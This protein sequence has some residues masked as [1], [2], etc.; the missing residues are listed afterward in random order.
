[1]FNIDSFGHSDMLPQILRG[2]GIDSYVFS[3]PESYHVELPDKLFVWRS[4]NGS[5]VTAYRAA[6]LY[7]H[8]PDEVVSTAEKYIKEAADR[9]GQISRIWSNNHGG[10]PTKAI[11]SALKN[12]E[13][14][15]M[16]LLDRLDEFF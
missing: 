16:R 4:P 5:T 9:S 13:S 10:A 8:T 7:Q 1:M 6:D 15:N 14:E 3:R 12:W 11:L 2:S